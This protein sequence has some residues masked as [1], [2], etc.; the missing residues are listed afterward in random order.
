MAER[1]ATVELEKLVANTPWYR[2][3]SWYVELESKDVLPKIVAPPTSPLHQHTE[4]ASLEILED[5]ST[6]HPPSSDRHDTGELESVETWERLEDE[7][8]SLEAELA[9][10]HDTEMLWSTF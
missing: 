9:A 6:A 7:A 10:T 2:A 5:T 8:R 4:N 3:P 1:D